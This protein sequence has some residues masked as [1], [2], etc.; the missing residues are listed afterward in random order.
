VDSL[1]TRTIRLRNPVVVILLY[2]TVDV[3]DD[4]TVLFKQDIYNRD[5]PIIRA[6]GKEFSFRKAQLIRDA[7][8]PPPEQTSGSS[9]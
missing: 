3:D 6:L 7:T 2:W 9:G 5:P 4:G 8:L 1:K